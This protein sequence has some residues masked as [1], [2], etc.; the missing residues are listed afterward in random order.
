MPVKI[1]LFV[2]LAFS[3]MQA[4]GAQL[5]LD[6]F[7]FEQN[8]GTRVETLV[9]D[10]AGVALSSEIPSAPPPNFAV[11]G[12]VLT[13]ARGN[14][15]LSRSF[16]LTALEGGGMTFDDDEG[17]GNLPNFDNALSIGDLD[18]FENDDWVITVTEG[19]PLRLFGFTLRDTNGTAGEVITLLDSAGAVIEV[20]PMPDLGSS[21]NTFVAVSYTHLTLPTIYSV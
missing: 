13:F 10:A 3:A 18:N 2:A 17:G 20:L 16:T 9:T 6:R 15:G 1:F 21:T 8:A 5:L 19:E 12:S 4:S 14:T 11:P 7:Q